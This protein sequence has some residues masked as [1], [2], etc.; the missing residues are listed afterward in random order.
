MKCNT[1]VQNQRQYTKLS[2]HHFFI[3]AEYILRISSEASSSLDS[4]LYPIIVVRSIFRT[5]SADIS[6]FDLLRHPSFLP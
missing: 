1:N 3:Q 2:Q 5:G 6:T 4:L